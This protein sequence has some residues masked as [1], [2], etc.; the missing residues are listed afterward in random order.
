MSDKSHTINIIDTSSNN[1]L[2]EAIMSEENPL[3]LTHNI[4]LKCR[5]KSSARNLYGLILINF[6]ASSSIDSFDMV[7]STF[8]EIY[9][10]DPQ[11]EWHAYEEQIVQTKW[12]GKYNTNI[13]RDL[14]VE[15][16]GLLEDSFQK[17]HL[18]ESANDYDFG[19]V[20]QIFFDYVKRIL[21]DKSLR[22]EVNIQEVTPAEIETYH[23]LRDQERQAQYKGPA[24]DNEYG[25]EE[26]A[27]IL[28]SSLVLAPVNGKPLYDLKLD[29]KIMIK[30]DP[31]SAK[32]QQFIEQYSLKTENNTY[33]PL[34]AEVIDIKAPTKEDPVQILLR[35]EKSVYAKAIE[36][37]RQVKLRLYNSGTDRSIQAIKTAAR[38]KKGAGELSPGPSYTN[39]HKH[40]ESN[41]M[42]IIL[43]VVLAA[44]LFILIIAIYMLL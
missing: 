5:F 2:M 20:E 32:N 16:E 19:T 7:A 36:E 24:E 42:V 27:S 12:N 43:S 17:T 15:F 34:P 41:N 3:D 23:H 21:Q 31:K 30:L 44:L 13:T 22:V 35:I 10:I 9:D 14:Q 40:A 26:G 38:Q 28:P 37:E 11:A 25:L 1:C 29:D 33:L 39:E 4:F 18:F 6:N 8:S